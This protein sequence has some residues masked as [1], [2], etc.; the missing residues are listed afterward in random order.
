MSACNAN[1]GGTWKFDIGAKILQSVSVS[2][3][4]KDT[5]AP[6]TKIM[7]IVYWFTSLLQQLPIVGI[8]TLHRVD[9]LKT[10][11]VKLIDLL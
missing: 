1:D 4:P 8:A 7:E 9:W 2:G 10:T 5:L 3:A 11:E 6:K